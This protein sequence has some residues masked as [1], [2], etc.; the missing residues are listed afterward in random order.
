MTSNHW[1][2]ELNDLGI[3]KSD[4][5]FIFNKNSYGPDVLRS[6][7]EVA[8]NSFNNIIY[9]YQN[10][11]HKDVLTSMGFIELS[12]AEMLPE[13]MLIKTLNIHCFIKYK[14]INKIIV[15][16]YDKHT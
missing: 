6:S 10:P 7:I 3:K 9:L 14:K 15:S 4:F 13:K 16:I 12:L 11:V 8:Q 1:A 2:S 5:I